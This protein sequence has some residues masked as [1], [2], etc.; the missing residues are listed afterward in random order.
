MAERILIADDDPTLRLLLETVLKMNGFEVV[1]VPNG[2]ALVRA[3]REILPDLL[4][5]DIV[6]PVMDGL[7]AIRQLRLDTR[8]GHLPMLLLTA[9]TTAEQQVI[10][11]ESGADDYITKPFNHDLLIARVKANLRRAARPPVSNPLTGLPGN[12]LIEEEVTYRL[13]NGRDFALLWIDLDNFKSFND[14]YGFARGDRV[15]RMLG[16]ILREMKRERGHDEDFVGHIGGDDFVILANPAHAAEF[17]KQVIAGFD[18]GITPLYDA[19]DLERGYLLGVDRWG[20]VRRFPIISLSIGIVDTT[21][22]DFGAYD[23]ISAVAAEVKGFAKKGAGSSYAIDKRSFS[24]PP[25][26][27]RRGLPPLVIIMC[28]GKQLYR[29]LQSTVERTGSRVRTFSTSTSG[30]V[31]S[32]LTAEHPDLILLDAALPHA[33]RTLAALR[34]AMPGLPIVMLVGAPGEANRALAAGAH[35]AVPATV[36]PE[37]LATTIAQLLR[38]DESALPLDQMPA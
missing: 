29:R 14:A 25:L 23:Q 8:T 36:T 37:Q 11:F 31:T 21:G 5:I 13:R 32:V 28:M 26:A 9:N 24:I 12:V 18:A 6:M 3:A 4:L 33:W 7:E 2:D 35:A 15:I 30:V 10:G 34:A 27:D 38:L 17:S 1:S 22:R 19:A 16:D 20:I